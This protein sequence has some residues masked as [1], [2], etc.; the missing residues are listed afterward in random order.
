MAGPERYLKKTKRNAR[1]RNKDENKK[2]IENENETKT[3]LFVFDWGGKA[4]QTPPLNTVSQGAA[5]LQTSC[6]YFVPPIRPFGQ[7]IDCLI[8]ASLDHIFKDSS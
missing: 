5:G 1:K 7:W 6:E 8:S 2:E 4:P 3:C